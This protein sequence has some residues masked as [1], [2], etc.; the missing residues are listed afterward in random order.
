MFKRVFLSYLLLLSLA[1]VIDY[2]DLPQLDAV[3]A[4]TKV[5]AKKV[6]LM[7][8]KSEGVQCEDYPSNEP[9]SMLEIIEEFKVQYPVCEACGCPQSSY[10]HYIR[11]NKFELELALEQ[12]YKKVSKEELKEARKYSE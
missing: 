8:E 7:K 3:S 2:V 10:G 9:E 12:G 11:I 5:M 4:A 1:F 6:W